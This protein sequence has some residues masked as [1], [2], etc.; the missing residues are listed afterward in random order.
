MVFDSLK[1]LKLANLGET[2]SLK[3]RYFYV[4]LLSGAWAR[5]LD[6]PPRGAICVKGRI[7][8]MVIT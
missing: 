2:D 3:A 4:K 1:A 7:Y 6:G 5:T 8:K